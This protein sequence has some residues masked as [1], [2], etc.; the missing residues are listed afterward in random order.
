MFTLQARLVRSLALVV[1]FVL[2]SMALSEDSWV[3]VAVMPKE[4]CTL[5]VG[6][7]RMDAAQKA[8][9]PYLVREVNGSWFWVSDSDGCV[10]GWVKGQDIVAIDDAIAYY[11]GLITAAPRDSWAYAL[12]GVA[13]SYTFEDDAIADFTQAIRLN[14]KCALAYAYRGDAW[15][16]KDVDKAVEDLTNAIHIDSTYA[17]A[18]LYRANAWESKGEFD[19][20][21]ADCTKALHLYPQYAVAYGRRGNAWKKNKS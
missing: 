13:K 8:E 4:G 1:L 17:L 16:G 21:I 6:N 2:P 14:P 18:Y 3:G 15:E 12:R 5:H 20:V 10:A 7:R 9:L 11:T 19:K